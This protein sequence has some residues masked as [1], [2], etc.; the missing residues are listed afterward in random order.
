LLKDIKPSIDQ[1]QIRIL[2]GEFFSEPVQA[3]E[4]V[5]G[6]EVAQTLSF[7]VAGQE[8]IFRINPGSMA[9]SF[10]K[11]VFIYRNFASSSLPIPPIVKVGRQGEWVYAI[12]YKMQGSG[13]LS[14]PPKEIQE[15][16]PELIRTLHTIHTCDVSR[17]TGYGL[18]NDSGEGL[19]GS[20]R[21]SL[22]TVIEEETDGFFANWHALFATT[23][24]ERDFFD[25]VY[26][27]MLS[28][29]DMCP[30]ERYLVHGDFGYNNVL[31]QQGTIT[32]VLDWI[33]AQYG[34]F[35]YDIAWLDFWGRNF[36]FPELIRK[37]YT[38]QGIPLP[39]YEERIACYQAYIGL[40]AMRF[41]AKVQNQEAYKYTRQVLKT[42]L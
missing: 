13:L 9:A 40:N 24:L 23:F 34:D 29:L 14:L 10:Y 16:L 8:Y 22:A 33:N 28:L 5:E 26:Q 36:N 12:S 21:S 1:K 6:G 30:E 42:T 31:A 7:R 11:E 15:V 18:F 35:V 41:Y 19:A 39:H 38:S 27:H 20:W 2:L 17:W 4:P 25:T 3:L 32:A 37:F